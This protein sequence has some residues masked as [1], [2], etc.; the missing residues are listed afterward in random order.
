[1]RITGSRVVVVEKDF[2]ILKH[3][4]PGDFVISMRSF[5]GGLEYSCISGCISSAYVMISSRDK[6]IT[7]D[8]YYKWLFKSITYIDA[9]QST[10]Q[11]IRDGQ[12]MRYSNFIKIYIPTPPLNEQ[13]N[14][15]KHLDIRVMGINDTIKYKEQFVDEIS[16]Y[17]KI[18]IYEYVTGKK[19]V[20]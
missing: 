2:S 17:K 20:I 13:V 4:E 1:M 19:E 11:L 7:Y 12:A 15:S 16:N 3:V 18:L 6:G 8:G 5:Q 14:I 9:L 10:S